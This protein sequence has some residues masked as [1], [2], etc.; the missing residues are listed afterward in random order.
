ML[1][2]SFDRVAG[3]PFSQGPPESSQ[4]N[5]ATLAFCETIW[6]FY[7][8]KNQQELYS[9]IYVTQL[10]VLRCEQLPDQR[11][12][13]IYKGPQ[14]SGYMSLNKSAKKRTFYE[15]VDYC[16]IVQMTLPEAILSKQL[17]RCDWLSSSGQQTRR[18]R[19]GEHVSTSTYLCWS[20]WLSL[21]IQE[22]LFKFVIN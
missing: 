18:Q 14:L 2:R 1:P 17:K 22:F 21:E 10:F 12:W 15:N 8:I 6:K 20:L 16:T 19:L 4:Q 9:K 13:T 3:Q 7:W 5:V 11:P